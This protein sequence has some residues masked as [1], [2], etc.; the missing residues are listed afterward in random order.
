MVR[1]SVWSLALFVLTPTLPSPAQQPKAD[2]E[3]GF[4]V[5]SLSQRCR[6]R[7]LVKVCS[8]L[9][10]ALN[11][12]ADQRG[13][14]SPHNIEVTTGSEGKKVPAGD[15]VLYHVYT[16]PGARVGWKRQVIL[17]DRKNAD[18]AVKTHKKNGLEV[19]IV[20]DHAPREVY[21]VYGVQCRGLMQLQSTHDSLYSAFEAVHELRTKKKFRC[22]VT[23]GTK[24]QG[25]LRGMPAEYKVYVEGG[26]CG[27]SLIETTKEAKKAQEV[28]ASRTKDR[29]R[30]EIVHHYPSK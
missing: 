18:E 12:A 13:R 23:T 22:E 1:T 26:R 3:R 6:T 29:W 14:T 20:T 10:Y 9:D 25:T 15:P 21:H 27:W 2:D 19:E 24:G 30:V 8:S 11:V 5:Y 17:A 7:T 16:R 28:A 4:R